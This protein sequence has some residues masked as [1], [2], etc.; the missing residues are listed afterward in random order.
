MLTAQ[1]VGFRIAARLARLTG[2]LLS[3]NLPLLS[4][5]VRET[6]AAALQATHASDEIDA[7][8]RS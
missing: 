6:I 4:T 7:I 5:E 1:V 3:N 2:R 8:W